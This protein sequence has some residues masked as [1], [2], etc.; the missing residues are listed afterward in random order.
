MPR[1]EVSPAK[2]RRPAARFAGNAFVRL[3]GPIEFDGRRG[4]G[5]GSASWGS[6]GAI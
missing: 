3:T 6:A 2:P 4:R 5:R 1:K